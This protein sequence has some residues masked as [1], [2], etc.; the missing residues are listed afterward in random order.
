MIELAKID[1]DDSKFKSSIRDFNHAYELNENL[2]YVYGKIVHTKMLL[3]DWSDF[4]KQLKIIE[5]ALENNKRIII[6]FPLL[7]L[8]DDPQKH[9]DNSILFAK[10]YVPTLL[11]NFKKKITNDKIKIGYFSADLN[12]HAVSHLICK[13]FKLHDREKF[14]IYCY[15]FGFREKDKLHLSIQ[16]DVDVYRDI[17]NINDH[18]ATLLAREDKIDI[19]IDLQGYTNKQRSQIFVNRAA[20]IQINYLG[21]PGTMGADFIDYII[22]DKNLIPEESQ[23]FYSEKLIYM[24]HHYQVQ[25]DELKAAETK[26]SKEELGLPKDSFVFCATNN[27]YKILPEVFDVWMK[28][29][30]SV[31]R[32]V[33]WLLETNDIAK[34]NLLKEAKAKNITSDRIVFMKKTSHKVYLSQIKHADL[35]LDTFVYNAGATASNAL[36]MGVPIL[37]KRG[38]SYTSRM[39]SSLLHSIGLP[40]L[41]TTNTKDYL[42]LAIELATNS[43]KLNSIKHKL[44]ENRLQKPLFDTK[45]FTHNFEEGLEK[46]YKN[47]IEGN[48]AKNISISK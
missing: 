40:E 47:Y 32:S 16:Q 39:A 21:Y 42:N 9:R 8:V 23:K 35:F 1:L 22:A 10:T 15:A 45:L 17:R 18:D 3:N 31:E 26:P 25:N 36:W 7:S 13:M 4:D 24:P 20:P 2:D 30:N 33:L 48:R 6:P 34:D 5:N 41:I 27:T 19:A 44:K 29:L 14:K 37:T 38:Q 43:K 46:V 11:N 28:L 12:E